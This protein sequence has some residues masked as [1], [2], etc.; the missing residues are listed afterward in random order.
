M[1]EYDPE[2]A[3]AYTNTDGVSVEP[4]PRLTHQFLLNNKLPVYVLTAIPPQSLLTF[5]IKQGGG[6]PGT[7]LRVPRSKFPFNITQEIPPEVL[8]NGGRDVWAAVDKSMLVLVW[9]G[10]AEKMNVGRKSDENER[11]KISKWST[12]NVQK[13]KEVMENERILRQARVAAENAESEEAAEQSDPVNAR[14]MDVVS[15][16]G[17]GEVKLD[18]A[19]EEFDD[20]SEV[21]TERDFQYAITN[22][23]GGK[24]REWLQAKLASGAVATAPKKT[25]KKGMAADVEL[26]AKKAKKA[27]VENVFDDQEP[28][29]TDEEREAEK[30]AEAMARQRQRPYG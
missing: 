8:R 11:N 12:Q 10:D 5:T 9:P 20:L 24:L 21:M 27:K 29:M 17:S 23:K 25:K 26:P 13:S 15:R 6:L 1:Y 2:N 30:E 3:E 22:V 7:A 19:I 28:E 18:K 16:V 14:V 4:P